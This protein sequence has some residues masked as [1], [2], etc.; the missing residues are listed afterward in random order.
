MSVHHQDAAARKGAITTSQAVVGTVT[1]I[2]AL[3]MPHVFCIATAINMFAVAGATP[4]M[5]RHAGPVAPTIMGLAALGIFMV[6]RQK[7]F[8]CHWPAKAASL[9]AVAVMAVSAATAFNAV[10]ERSYDKIV[11]SAAK[12]WGVSAEEAAEVLGVVCG[13]GRRQPE[14][15]VRP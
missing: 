9:G 15:A 12:Q 1:G 2:A 13:A 7:R 5:A 8:C 14:T 11:Y 10:T 3:A 4:A 6:L